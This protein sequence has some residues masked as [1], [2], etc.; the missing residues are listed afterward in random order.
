M[1]T[2]FCPV[3]N[4]PMMVVRQIIFA[5]PGL[6]Q[7]FCQSPNLMLRASRCPCAA[8]SSAAGFAPVA[9]GGGVAFCATAGLTARKA[10]AIP[11]GRRGNPEGHIIMVRL[12]PLPLFELV[13]ERRNHRRPDRDGVR[14]IDE[15]MA[16]ATM[17]RKQVIFGLAAGTREGRMHSLRQLG[18]EIG[19][20]LDIHPEHWD[21]GRR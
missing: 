18:P 21:A 10:S 17:R 16:V 12:R 20:V 19:V 15:E 1:R 2:A 6:K 13:E 14:G 7:S 9:A 11:R 8:N 5:P 3:S 4:V